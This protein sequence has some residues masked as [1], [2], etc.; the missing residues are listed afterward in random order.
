MRIRSW[1]SK[2]HRRGVF[3]AVVAIGSA[4]FTLGAAPALRASPDGGT[5]DPLPE[6]ISNR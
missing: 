3:G 6:T 1:A 2:V 4:A 5:S